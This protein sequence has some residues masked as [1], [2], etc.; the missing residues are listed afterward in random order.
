[1]TQAIHIAP[2]E[3]PAYEDLQLKVWLDVFMTRMETG[4][5]IDYAA[6]H[7]DRAVKHFKT[8]RDMIKGGQ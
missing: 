1:M 6:A 2:I 5:D 8:A 7:A 4:E 3:D